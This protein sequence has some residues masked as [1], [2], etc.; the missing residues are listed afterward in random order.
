M[1]NAALPVSIN[2]TESALLVV[3]T[4]VYPKE[5]LRLERL[6]AGAANG[7]EKPGVQ[8]SDARESIVMVAKKI[9]ALAPACCSTLART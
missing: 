7:V 5:R 3:P 4:A 8:G 2:L 6:I 1:L 9:D